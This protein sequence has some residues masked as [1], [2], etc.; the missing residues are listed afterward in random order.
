MPPNARAV[1]PEKGALTLPVLD[2]VSNSTLRFNTGPYLSDL[3]QQPIKSG[4][5]PFVV[6]HD[7]M[8][9]A[10]GVPAG[11]SDHIIPMDLQATDGRHYKIT[12]EENGWWCW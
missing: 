7:D 12:D 6:H 11:A 4:L 9:A 8:H 1:R 5:A 3:H 2:W 10:G